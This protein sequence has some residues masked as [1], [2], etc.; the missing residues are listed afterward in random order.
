MLSC[1]SPYW[2]DVVLRVRTESVASNY[3]I[4]ELARRQRLNNVLRDNGNVRDK[5]Q[6]DGRWHGGM[7]CALALYLRVR[8]E[9]PPLR[10]VT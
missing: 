2:S 6:S 9:H 3:I 10:P 5:V 1:T 7:S 4:L 8:E